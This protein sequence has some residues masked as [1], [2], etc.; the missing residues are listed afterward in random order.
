MAVVFHCLVQITKIMNKIPLQQNA[1]IGVS[2]IN[3]LEDIFSLISTLENEVSPCS[4]FSQS[5]WIKAWLRSIDECPNA[6]VFSISGK[7]IGL[8]LVGTRTFSSLLP[9]REGFLNQTGLLDEDQIWVEYNEVYCNE[10]YKT[11][12]TNAL[13][14]AF[15]KCPSNLRLTISMV[16]DSSLWHTSIRNN[17]FK[18]SSKRVF[19]YKANLDSWC[20]N[21]E[22]FN[23]I[24]SNTR[25]HLAR[26][27]KTLNEYFGNIKFTFASRDQATTYFYELGKFH[28]KKWGPTNEGSGFNNPKFISHHLNFIE[29]NWSNVDLIKVSAGNHLLGFV[30][31][32]IQESTVYFYCSGINHEATHKHVKPG[33]TI[34][35][36]LMIHYKNNGYE[37][38]DFLG[39]ENQYK[40]SLSDTSYSFELLTVYRSELTFK[41]SKMMKKFIGLLKF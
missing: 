1:D 38:Y 7:A 8:A 9:F 31:N 10:E 14:Q 21:R 27:L 40:K 18:H 25:R 36:Q 17:V 16:S 6:F 4:F 32:I 26:S 35:H 41:I 23:F 15:F 39:G 33:Y 12:C 11:Q 30:Y 28:I 20:D 24:S 2:Q 5:H 29:N 3:N 19:G 34:H 22:E 37:W 13:L